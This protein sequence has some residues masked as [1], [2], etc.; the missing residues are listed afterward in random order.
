MSNHDYSYSDSYVTE[1][2]EDIY[3]TELEADDELLDYLGGD[4]SLNE[5]RDLLTL[6][7][8]AKSD[9]EKIWYLER[10]ADIFDVPQYG[11]GTPPTKE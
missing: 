2:I 10:I 4:S 7:I 9:L 11:L 6:G 8:R 5:I 3:G 1:I